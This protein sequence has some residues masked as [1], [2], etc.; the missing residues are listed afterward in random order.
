MQTVSTAVRLIRTDALLW[1]WTF[2]RKV[3]SLGVEGA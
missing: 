2:R 3:C 1:A